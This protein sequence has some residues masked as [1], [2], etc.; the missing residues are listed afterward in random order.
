MVSEKTVKRTHF[1]GNPVEQVCTKEFIHGV[2]MFGSFLS[3]V[4]NKK[5]NPTLLFTQVLQNYEAR[6]L[7]IHITGSQ[8]VYSSLLGLLHL[9]PVLIKSKN[10][11][12]LFNTSLKKQCND[13]SR[14]KNI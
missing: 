2:F 3:M 14:K 1:Q 7:F 10:T 13:R 4:Y 8:D 12:K 11:K 9:Y 5:V 6:E